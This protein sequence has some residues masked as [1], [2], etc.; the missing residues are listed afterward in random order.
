[1]IR[2]KRLWV[3]TLFLAGF[4]WAPAWLA[5]LVLYEFGIRRGTDVAVFW[6]EGR[7]GGGRGGRGNGGG[8][9]L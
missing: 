2:D 9:L 6:V 4:V 8:R 3:V 1:M 7:F 5:A